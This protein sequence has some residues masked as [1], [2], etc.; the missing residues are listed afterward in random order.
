MTKTQ[1]SVSNEMYHRPVQV[2]RLGVPAIPAPRDDAYPRWTAHD[3][4]QLLQRLVFPPQRGMAIRKGVCVMTP[5]MFK[6]F[7]RGALKVETIRGRIDDQFIRNRYTLMV[8]SQI[9]DG[10]TR[11][12]CWEFGNGEPP[13]FMGYT[14]G[15][16]VSARLA[17]A[18]KEVADRYEP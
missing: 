9:N 11:K 5:G 3:T 16:E 18:L 15:S 6:L 7:W 12:C 14:S 13:R 1:G 10:D 4:R 17:G 2:R 8:E